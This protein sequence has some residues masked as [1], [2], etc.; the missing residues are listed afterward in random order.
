LAAGDGFTAGDGA[1]GEDCAQ[2]EERDRDALAAPRAQT[3]AVR[4]RDGADSI[5]FR[6]RLRQSP[7]PAKQHQRMQARCIWQKIYLTHWAATAT[8]SSTTTPTP[9]AR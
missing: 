3:I 1:P 6:R 2:M 9:R 5:P 8:A 7:C 4:A